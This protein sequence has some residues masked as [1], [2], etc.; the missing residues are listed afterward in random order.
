MHWHAVYG[1]ERTS[2][3]AQ[4]IVATLDRD[5]ETKTTRALIDEWGTNTWPIDQQAGRPQ[6]EADTN[7]LIQ[8]LADR[9]ADPATL[10]AFL[11]SC[12]NGIK[13]ATGKSDDRIGQLFIG[14][15]LQKNLDLARYIVNG[16]LESNATLLSSHAGRALGALLTA[17]RDEGITV[18]TQMLD[19]GDTHIEVIAEGYMFAMHPDAYEEV[20]LTALRCIFRSE[21][22]PVLR[23][24]SIITRE[25]ARHNKSLAID[26]LSSANIDLAVRSARDY[27]MWLGHEDTIPFDLIRDDQLHLFL[28][29]LRNVSRLDD[30]WINAF[31]KKAITRAP[32]AV[33][34]LAKARIET[35]IANEDWSM[36]PLG[37]V[38]HDG[39]GPLDLLATTE[40]AAIFRNVLDWARKRIGDYQF[41]YR[42]A[43]L[44]Q[45]LC[46]PYD[47][48]FVEILEQWLTAGGTADH[49]KVVTAIV[50][51]ACASFAF[52]FEDFIARSLR[53]ARSVGRKAYGDLSSA[54]F[55]SAVSGVRSGAPGQPFDADVRLKELAE[56]RLGRITRA[57]PTYDLYVAI[58]D[59]ASHE[60]ERQLADGRRMDE[61][62]RDG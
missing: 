38:L 7:K 13:E 24:A 59:H 39:D 55:A 54:I 48:R 56:T 33:I 11:G 3:T 15:L 62:D 57:D 35:S 52:D 36:Q 4:R 50:R 58:R 9:F 26:L 41:S 60:I 8:E 22:P 45:S 51:D 61:E 21:S 44:V 20:D 18:V 29:G 23:Y 27:F 17:R 46:S 14:R 19:G 30:F 53:A 12:L 10:A 37:S 2:T 28:D 31:L 6:H 1:P 25:V 42:F 5:I 34:D 49:F 43:E 16:R 47:T 32:G 40:G